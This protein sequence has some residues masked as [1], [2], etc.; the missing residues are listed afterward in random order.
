MRA[1]GRAWQA[2]GA[3]LRSLHEGPL[4]P[5]PDRSV[6]QPH[7]RI[8]DGRA[9]LMTNQVLPDEVIE[10]NHELAPGVIDWSEARRS[11]PVYD[12]A[13]LALGHPGR[14]DDLLAV[15]LLEC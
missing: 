1:V 13:T 3:T 5:W 8:D 11:D 10:R 9:W 15:V 6:D 12:I 4:P 7:A 2:V 14:L